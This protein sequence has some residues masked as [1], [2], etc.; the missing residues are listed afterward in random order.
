MIFFFFLILFYFFIEISLS[1][2]NLNDKQLIQQDLE[3]GINIY[4][5]G[6][7]QLK[8]DKWIYYFFSLIF[9]ILV[10]VLSGIQF[11]QDN[12]FYNVLIAIPL[13][14]IFCYTLIM[15]TLWNRIEMNALRAG[16]NALTI[17]LDNLLKLNT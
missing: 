8:N 5:R 15:A 13:I 9:L 11:L 6:L 17:N 10:L 14:A 7:K 1:T 12:M 4:N 2:I 16:L 3:E